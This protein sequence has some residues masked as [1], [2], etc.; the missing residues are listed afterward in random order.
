MAVQSKLEQHR[1]VSDQSITSWAEVAELVVEAGKDVV[2]LK[3]KRTH[4]QHDPVI[5]TLSEAQR[6]VRLSLQSATNDDHVR[7]LKSERNR[8]LH[9]IRKRARNNAEDKLTAMAQEVERLKDGAQMFQAVR[10]IT[11][12]PAAT[13]VIHDSEGKVIANSRQACEAISSHFSDQFNE[14]NSVATLPFTGQPRPLCQP[15][16]IGEVFFNDMFATHVLDPMIGAG[17]LIPLPKPGKPAGPPTSLRP[18]VLL[19]TMRK[20]LSLITL[21]RI[22]GYV[23]EYLSANQS[24]FRQ[25]RSTADVVWCHRWLT[26]KAQR[27]KWEFS[28]LGIDMS[29]AF[30]TI[31]RDKLIDVLSSFLPEDEVRLIRLLIAD[32]KLAVRVGSDL[33]DYFTTT[34]GTP[35]GD[36]ISP[37]LFI[38]YLEAA[39]RSIRMTTPRAQDTSRFLPYDVEYADDVD[40]F[41]IS[42]TWLESLE[43]SAATILEEWHLHV[44]RS[45]TEYTNVSRDNNEWRQVKKLGSL[46]GD[47]QDMQRRRILAS[48]TFKSMWNL[49]KQHSH[50]GLALR[51]RL[52]NAFVLPILLYNSGTWGTTVADILSME[53]CH[54]HHL[55]SILG[56][57]WPDHITNSDLYHR[58]GS[59]P[60][61]EY[62]VNARWRLFGHILRLEEQA[63]AQ[64]AMMEYFDTTTCSGFR[65]RPITTLPVTINNDLK[66]AGE[67]PMKSLSDL[68]ALQK[69][70]ACR[71]E[72]SGLCQRVLDAHKTQSG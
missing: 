1:S 68:N 46:L 5:E 18:I 64:Q 42:S 53:T 39:L 25:K 34:I 27:Y 48:A 21:Q 58:T 45:K 6:N 55:R 61:G 26:A 31:C 56:I 66:K 59:T 30:D 43:P 52:Y 44:N 16:S 33:S 19:T 63:P 15:I 38:V 28:I 54:R 4:Q 22:N 72:W 60:I 62:V 24:G 7:T 11:R 41:S 36:S 51:I 71:K 70:A 20:T 40:F 3:S 9:D 50:I 13:P 12:K 37:V 67:R 29:R 32:T 69:L 35:Q 2:G 23:Q 47:S 57:R 49:W 65:G 17:T 14:S 10:L 8:I